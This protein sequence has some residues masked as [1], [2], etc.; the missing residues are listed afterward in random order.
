MDQIVYREEI[1]QKD[2]NNIREIVLST[3]FFRDDEIRIAVELAEERLA[4]GPASG[5]HFIFAEI[6]G[7]VAAYCCYGLIPCSLSSYDIYWIATK[8]GIQGKG[9]GSS[10]LSKAEAIIASLGGKNIFLETSSKELYEPTRQFYLRNGY[11]TEAVLSD[12]YEPGDAKVILRK[13]L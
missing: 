3:R 10:L 1:K 11:A 6:D 8:A 13:R 9:V 4:N 7:E 12:F 2:V 5:Y